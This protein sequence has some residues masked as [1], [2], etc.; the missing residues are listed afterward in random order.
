MNLIISKTEKHGIEL[1]ITPESVTRLELIGVPVDRIKRN[2]NV[3]T[4][5]EYFEFC[6]SA[7]EVVR[8]IADLLYSR[9]ASF[10]VV[11]IVVEI[12][13]N[14][15]QYKITDEGVAYLKVKYRLKF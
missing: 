13:Y 6:S 7:I 14:N 4:D 11:D 2:L 15:I 10:K 8:A 12:D 5:Y 1:A 3:K 9:S